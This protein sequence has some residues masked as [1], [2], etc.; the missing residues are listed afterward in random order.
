[1]KKSSDLLNLT[2]ECMTHHRMGPGPVPGER[3]NA[4]RCQNDMSRQVCLGS[5]LRP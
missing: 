5:P 4:Q 1:M 2:V 3:N